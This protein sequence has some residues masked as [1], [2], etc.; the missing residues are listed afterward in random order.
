MNVN[1]TK[2]QQQILL[3]HAKLTDQ[4]DDLLKDCS[5]SIANANARFTPKRDQLRTDLRVE[6]FWISWTR[7]S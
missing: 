1:N 6:K 2:H 5:N 3:H 7:Q 4:F